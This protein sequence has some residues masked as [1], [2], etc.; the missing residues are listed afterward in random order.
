MSVRRKYRLQISCL[1]LLNSALI[2]QPMLFA[3]SPRYT[4]HDDLSYYLS[5]SGGRV[6]I[7][8]PADWQRRRAQILAGMQEVM[9]SLIHI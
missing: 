3:E 4:E 9:L 2:V 6:P 5:A 1:F 7:R 8:T